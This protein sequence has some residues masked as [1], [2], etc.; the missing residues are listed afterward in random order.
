MLASP[1][2]DLTGV[3]AALQRGVASNLQNTVGWTACHAAAAAGHTKVISCLLRAGA[4]LEMRDRGGSTPLH[5]AC[6][7]G[8][9]A[10]VQLLAGAGG[11]LEAV[12]LSQTKGPAVR[13]MVL[14]AMRAAGRDDEAEAPEPVG[15]ARVQQRSNAFYGPRRTP[16]SGKLKKQLLRGKRARKN[17]KEQEK[18]QEQDEQREKEEHDKQHEHEHEEQKEQ[19]DT[20]EQDE[21]EEGE[22]QK[23]QQE[24]EEQDEQEEGEEQNVTR[25][26]KVACTADVSTPDREQQL[27]SCGKGGSPP[28]RDSY[29][30]IYRQTALPVRYTQ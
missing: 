15:Y 22:E 4:D 3:K 29:Q 6:R 2:G 25:E 17:S 7:G 19:Q 16:I 23:E 11:K 20:G 14:E 28:E 26:V 8:H 30:V 9:A 5:E 1:Q 12:R 27:D 24:K 13:A 21:Q 10:A 18:Q